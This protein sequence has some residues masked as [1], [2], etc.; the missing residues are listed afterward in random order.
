MVRVSRGII[1]HTGTGL[2]LW[3]S[4][5]CIMQCWV[6][7]DSIGLPRSIVIDK[8]RLYVFIVNG[9]FYVQ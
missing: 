1:R 3:S 6:I 7:F 2:I 9:T 4:R 5:E 8:H